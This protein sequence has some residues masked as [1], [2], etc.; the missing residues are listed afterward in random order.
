M[1]FIQGIE[2]AEKAFGADGIRQINLAIQ[3]TFGVDS[4]KIDEQEWFDLY[5]KYKYL[6]KVDQKII[7]LAVTEALY[8]VLNKI[9]SGNS[10]DTMDNGAG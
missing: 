5:A 9:F 2:E 7:T 1:F 6:K 3:H 4:T 8:D 10:N